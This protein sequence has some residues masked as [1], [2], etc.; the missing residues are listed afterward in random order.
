M[1]LVQGTRLGPY[2][3]DAPLGAGGM[4]EVY[5]ATD[6][7]L[8][9]EVAIKVLS[10]DLA[11]SP[12][13]RLRFERE[14][15][16]ISSLSHPNICMLFD[17]GEAEIPSAAAG[18]VVGGLEA[19]GESRSISY[20]V[21]ECLE[22]E[23]L[24][25]RLRRGALPLD[26]ALRMGIEIADALD[27]AHRRGVVHRDLKP[28]NIMLTPTGAKLLDFGLA[29]K[30]MLA[31][32]SDPDGAT[33]RRTDDS[34]PLTDKGTIVG[35]FQYMAPEQLDGI[36]AD[37][38]TDIF[39][40]GAVLY[41]AVTGRR[42]FE[43]TTKSSLIASIVERHPEPISTLI[44]LTPPAL[45][46]LVSK[47]LEKGREGRWQCCHDIAEQLR[48]I[49][50]SRAEVRPPER[51]SRRA[52]LAGWAVAAL[53]AAGTIT[54]YLMQRAPVT[55]PATPLQFTIAAPG[56]SPFGVG[57]AVSPDG[58]NVAFRASGAD[59][60]ARLWIRSLSSVESR[61]LAGTEGGAFPFWAPDGRRIGF[62]AEGKLRK[63]DLVTGQVL[64]ICDA[65]ALQ[66]GGGGTWNTDDVIVFAP[67]WDGPL[68]RVSASGGTPSPLATFDAARGDAAHIWPHFLPDGRQF[69]VSVVG[70]KES[71]LYT[72]SLDS[73][74]LRLV[75]PERQPNNLSMTYFADGY[76]FYVYAL[77][78]F[79]EEFD[80]ATQA[81]KGNPVRI[82]D[83]LDLWGPGTT[84]LG[85]SGNVLAFRE[86][87][88][89]RPVKLHWFTPEGEL[90]R[91]VGEPG[92]FNE[93]S[94][95]PDARRAAVSQKRS[96][97]LQQIAIV[98]LERGVT[99][100][101]TNSE[102][103]HGHP[104]WTEDGSGI[105]YSVAADTPPNLFSYD[106]RSGATSRLHRHRVQSY[107][108][109]VS[110]DGQQ[111]LIHVAGQGGSDLVT[112]PI[113]GGEMVPLLAGP[114]AETNGRFSPDGRSIAW[115]SNESGRPEIY[116]AS[117]PS[118]L[119][120]V[121]ISVD[122]GEEPEWAPDGH[123][124]YYRTG[125][126]LL[127]VELKPGSPHSASAPREILSVSFRNFRV[128]RDG[129]ILLSVL[130]DPPEVTP[131][132]VIVN[133]KATLN[134]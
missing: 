10:P 58:D 39:A 99:T 95:S 91:A 48:W 45:E 12:Q 60:Q 101:L 73:P 82:A 6:P 78:L 118:L 1:T 111:L 50:G 30:A 68:F 52:L 89:I 110:P 76:I 93:F 11:W 124:I 122:G 100:A 20:L 63:I 119:G 115:Q 117:Y 23:T 41:E 21:M 126:R 125:D 88:P 83:A 4:G 8:E 128:A 38:R 27:K 7:R 116:V 96:G 65:S 46:H 47:C 112:M 97:R 24:A 66:F 80:L 31:V 35:T 53:L 9:R 134:R 113:G 107:V 67:D 77:A 14:A 37:A 104:A 94:V 13:L 106:E 69:L 55:P 103:W 132:R 92:A 121:K 109:D 74:E 86:E 62:F 19:A 56:G 90:L 85:V 127:A 44:P 22:G 72:G 29:K 5:R 79:A 57:L 26:Q 98:D 18:A 114:A 120:K 34:A 131:I 51:S 42:A 71:G 49:A 84:T 15:K 40:F 87:Q 123:R 16:T 59:G 3:I 2:V 102:H 133:W 105:V 32:Q 33:E 43:G 129:R 54:G 64:T 81:V 28:G 130:A 75:R 108:G 17:V 36:E 70:E 25:A 61:P